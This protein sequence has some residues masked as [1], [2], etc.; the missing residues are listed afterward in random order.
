MV[1][2][3]GFYVIALNF[4]D[5]KNMSFH[6]KRAFISKNK[7][8]E[9]LY[10]KEI[11]L[12]Y[13]IQN[14]NKEYYDQ[15]KRLL[16]KSADRIYQKL[17][18]EKNIRYIYYKHNNQFLQEK[19]LYLLENS[20]LKEI[21]KR[22]KKKIELEIE[23]SNPF[24]IPLLEEEEEVSFDDILDKYQ[25]LAQR[26]IFE[27]YNISKDKGMIL[28]LVKPKGNVTDINFIRDF[29]EKIRS[30]IQELNLQ[31]EKIIVGYTGTYKLAID[32]YQSLVGSLKPISILSLFGI[33][34]LLILFF[35]NPI[36]LFILILSLISGIGLTF[37][38]S[39]FV[40]GRLNSIS[41]MMAS[42]LMGLGID[43]GIQF[44][45][46]FREEFKDKSDVVD[47]V[48]KTFYYTGR[49]SLTSAFTTT[50][51]FFVLIF[52]DFK[53]FSEFGIIACYGIFILAISMYFFT[54]LQIFF[55]L[56]LFPKTKK[57]FYYREKKV[58]NSIQID[59]IFIHYK[60]LLSYSLVLFFLIS[61]F[62][63][64]VKFNY[65]AKDL[66]IKGQKSLLITDEII[67]RFEVISE[68]QVAI[69]Q[70]LG[71]AEALCDFL[72][73]PPE[74]YR[75]I[76]KQAFCI[77]NLVPSQ[78]QQKENQKIIQ[79]AQED[80]KLVKESFLPQE[81]QSYLI[82]LNKM[83]KATPYQITDIPNSLSKIFKE[84]PESPEK[85]NLVFI[86][87]NTS[88]RDG[89]KLLEFYK[90]FGKLSYPKFSRKIL[91]DILYQ[92][93]QTLTSY[94][95][96]SNQQKKIILN[97][98]NSKDKNYFQSLKISQ[99][100]IDEIIKNRP[101]QSIENARKI[102][103]ETFTAGSSILYANL[104]QI[105]Q[106]EGF[107]SLWITLLII[108]IILS[109]SYKNFK[110][111]FF[112][113]FPIILGVTSMLGFMSLF[114]VH[115]NF[116]NILIFPIVLGYGIQ[117]TVYIHYRY[118]ESKD[119]AYTMSKTGTAVLV[120]SLTTLIGWSALMISDHR[121]LQSIGIV[122][123]IGIFSILIISFTIVP[124]FIV[125]VAKKN[126]N[127]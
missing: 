108:L 65:N 15:K 2:G 81:Y 73:P 90:Y 1:G 66:S 44:F 67:D 56:K 125:F 107:R 123:S 115:L 89:R 75:S 82:T 63:V 95:Q 126:K 106:K 99:K 118:Q 51:A 71:E 47:A 109:F 83:L 19:L 91:T 79:L 14:E 114:N 120:S 25:E 23:K 6:L 80:K 13:K 46:R 8:D 98:L 7:N 33:S 3:N 58:K 85:G 69:V 101:F 45:Y 116:M 78:A 87:P 68:P 97:T 17:K 27:D 110:N 86:Y 54:T 9:E 21:H 113:I 94:E 72:S 70:S 5:E 16:E 112:S 38:T 52:S 104:I 103:Y 42:I 119:I 76:F 124:S 39:Y 18:D 100:T 4:E 122:S 26:D 12:A 30:K 60:K 11:E 62:A 40:L 64:K 32:D 127:A 10:Q 22:A 29:D 50:S 92:E 84:V 43:Y 111:A 24:Y 36:V 96:L 28:M 102:Q 41:S 77:W 20:D 59:K 105:V 48:S 61:I 35:R 37:G 31:D 53:G 49:A 57:Y 34:V 88:L 55:I 74:N 117:N 121:G 93:T